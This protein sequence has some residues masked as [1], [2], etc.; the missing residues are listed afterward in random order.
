MDEE[1]LCG[2]GLL[3]H[4]DSSGEKTE[5]SKISPHEQDQRIRN[6]LLMMVLKTGSRFPEQFCHA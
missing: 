6:K 4:G 5:P 1:I 2:L 3:T